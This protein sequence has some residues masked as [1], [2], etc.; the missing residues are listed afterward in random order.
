MVEYNKN[1]NSKKKRTYNEM[2]YQVHVNNKDNKEEYYIHKAKQY[3]Y[4][5]KKEILSKRDICQVTLVR[6]RKASKMK[7]N[8]SKSFISNPL[9]SFIYKEVNK[10]NKPLTIAISPKLR[11]KMRADLKQTLSSRLIT[12][13][14]KFIK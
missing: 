12:P 14:L 13:K 2:M 7:Q 10:S 11:T 5:S 6:I 1:P 9:P 4:D 8:K 3:K